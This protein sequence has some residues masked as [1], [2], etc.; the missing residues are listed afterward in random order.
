M[1]NITVL[2]G[3]IGTDVTLSVST[4]NFTAT[5]KLEDNLQ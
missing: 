4:L 5:G 2:V 1:L 3:N